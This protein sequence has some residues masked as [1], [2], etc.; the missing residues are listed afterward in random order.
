MGHPEPKHLGNVKKVSL[1]QITFRH[2]E[3]LTHK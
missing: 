3:D 2:I 1:K